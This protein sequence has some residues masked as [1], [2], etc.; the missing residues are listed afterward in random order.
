MSQI[1][2][3]RRTPAERAALHEKIQRHITER[4]ERE[5]REHILEL[6]RQSAL[7]RKAGIKDDDDDE[8]DESSAV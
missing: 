2:K 7:K 3:I 5:V 6:V 4:C 1:K 8:D